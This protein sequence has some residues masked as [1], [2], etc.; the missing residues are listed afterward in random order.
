MNLYEWQELEV[1]VKD[2]HASILINGKV[3]AVE[4]FKEDLGKIVGFTYIMEGT[5]YIDYILLWDAKGKLTF[6]DPFEK[7]SSKLTQ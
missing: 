7:E 6:E 1:K 5:G 3:A 2:K 4:D